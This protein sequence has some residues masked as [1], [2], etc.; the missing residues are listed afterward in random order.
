MNRR[1]QLLV[2]AAVLVFL[3]FGVVI[4]IAINS[5]N[6]SKSSGAGSSNSI[7]DSYNLNVL[8]KLGDSDGLVAK[9]NNQTLKVTNLSTTTNVSNGSY[10]LKV[11]KPGYQD[12][13][14]QFNVMTNHSTIIN[15]V[16]TPSTVGTLNNWAQV[17]P[18]Y[19]FASQATIQSVS[20]FYDNNWAIANVSLFGS[21]GIAVLKY[22]PTDQKWQLVLGPGTSFKSSDI[23]SLPSDVSGYVRSHNYLA[24]GG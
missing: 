15:V 14:T 10:T 9:L 22:Q 11:S 20:Y 16:M 5:K 13:T 4:G 23:S 7:N 17:V 12:F 2:T 8:Y 3:I 18:A 24:P 19:Q 6:H 1:I 21:N